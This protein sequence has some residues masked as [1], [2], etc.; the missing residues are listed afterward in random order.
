MVSGRVERLRPIYAE[1][2]K[3]N[4]GAAAE[5]LAPDLVYSGYSPEGDVRIHG[6]QEF[7]RFVQG[8]LTDWEGYRVEADEFVQ[9]ED[10][11]VLVVGRHYGSG[12]RSGAA[13]DDP[14]FAVWVF[15]GEQVTGLHF[16]P[17]RDSALKA[18]GVRARR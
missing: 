13:V 15:R 6:L 10:D 7:G 17:D 18:A 11:V 14:L 9:V 16:Y 12:R 1:W 4:L 8:F 2:A 3:G 5:L